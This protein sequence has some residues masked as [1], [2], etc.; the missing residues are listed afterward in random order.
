MKSMSIW[1]VGTLVLSVC[2]IGRQAMGVE[3]FYTL[4]TSKTLDSDQLMLELNKSMQ[5]IDTGKWFKESV[6]KQVA[7]LLAQAKDKK[8][9]NTILGQFSVNDMLALNE[10]SL[11]KCTR[12]KLEEHRVFFTKVSS[13]ENLLEYCKKTYNNLNDWCETNRKY[14]LS[15]E[16]KKIGKGSKKKAKKFFEQVHHVISDDA[17]KHARAK[18]TGEIVINPL[19]DENGAVNY[20]R[21]IKPVL[22]ERGELYTKEL[23]SICQPFVRSINDTYQLEMSPKSI[24]H[25]LYNVITFYHYCLIVNKLV[26]R[27]YVNL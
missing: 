4:K 7:N 27:L 21:A 8:K 5:P 2:L 10:V 3:Y 24:D 9:P 22:K 12:S 20:E 11:D 1:F 18:K 6:G 14:L 13:N 17:K 25:S 23:H 26:E 15:D 16:L 19:A